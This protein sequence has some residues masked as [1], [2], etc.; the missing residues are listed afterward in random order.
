MIFHMYLPD[1]TKKS[2]FVITNDA[3]QVV[4]E[5]AP[6]ESPRSWSVSEPS[7][8]FSLL[9]VR[10]SSF[11]GENIVFSDATGIRGTYHIHRYDAM[12]TYKML[13]GRWEMQYMKKS[14]TVHITRRG[15]EVAS[16]RLLPQYSLYF[17][18]DITE[19]SELL[20][21]VGSLLAVTPELL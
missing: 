9:S 3:N 18:I 10:F 20:F 5:T 12:L 17:E 4:L 19:P 16:A 6:G 8:E 15:K 11:A 14:G 2:C 21:T 13:N 7:V 1:E